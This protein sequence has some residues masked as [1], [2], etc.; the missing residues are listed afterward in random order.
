MNMAGLIYK[1][2]LNLGLYL[3]IVQVEVNFF[4]IVVSI[5]KC[6]L[7]FSDGMILMM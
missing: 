4:L 3:S 5:L 1:G 2:L 7:S 6:V